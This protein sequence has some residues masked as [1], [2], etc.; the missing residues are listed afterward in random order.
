MTHAGMSGDHQNHWARLIVSALQVPLPGH[1][2]VAQN[3]I[4]EDAAAKLAI[5]IWQMIGAYNSLQT[6]NR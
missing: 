3:M 1:E 4:S 5:V 2:N 6:E